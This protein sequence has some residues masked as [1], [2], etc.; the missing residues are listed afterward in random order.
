MKISIITLFPAMLSGFFN[1]SIVQRAQEKKCVDIELVN[2]REYAVDT[3]GSVDDRPYG[4][5]VGMVLRVEPIYDALKKLKIKN[6]KEKIII[7][8]PKGKIYNQKKAYEYAHLDNLIIIAGHYEGID[9]RVLYYVDEEISMGNF[10]LTGGEIVAGAITDS[11]VRLL[12][13]VL[14]KENATYYESFRE[15]AIDDVVEAVGDDPLLIALQKK[16]RMT[17]RLLESAHYTRPELFQTAKVPDI[18]LSGNHK[19]IHLWQL[20]MAYKE[21]V[22]KRKDLLE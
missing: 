22:Q 15:V 12:P 3:Y 4:G 14:K 5:G 18:L 8:T 13:G 2:L 9:E 20:K 7:T 11:V 10:I 17:I 16:G 21:T 1:E 19:A 6:K